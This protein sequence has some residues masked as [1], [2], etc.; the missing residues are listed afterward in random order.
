MKVRLV[1]GETG[2]QVEG[3]PKEVLSATVR[4]IGAG[5]NIPTARLFLAR[6]KAVKGVSPLAAISNGEEK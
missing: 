3:T 4:Q 6:I 5:E 1:R 2:G